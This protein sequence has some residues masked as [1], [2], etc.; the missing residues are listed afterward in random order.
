LKHLAFLMQFKY[1]LNIL[2]F[3]LLA[4]FALVSGDTEEENQ[5]VIK[6]EKAFLEKDF[7]KSTSL[8]SQLLSSYPKNTNYNYK[9]GASLLNTS[10][11]K[12]SAL[13]YL[14]YAVTNNERDSL[15]LFYLAKAYHINFYFDDAIDYYQKFNSKLPAKYRAE[16]ELNDL[17]TQCKFAKEIIEDI[18]LIKV[19]ERKTVK[20][21]DFFRTYR[22]GSLERKIIIVPDEFR[23]AKDKK[24]QHQS[25]IVH[26]PNNDEIYF[27]S[28]GKKGDKGKDIYKVTRYPN[29]NFSEPINLGMN[30]N[31]S[32]DEDYPYLH[33]TGKILYFASK[34]H[35]SIGGY[36]IFRSELNES[37]NTW[38]K[39]ENLGFTINSPDDDFLYISDRQEDIAYFSSTRNNKLGELTLFKILP[40]QGNNAVILVQGTVKTKNGII[41]S[42]PIII[43]NLQTGELIGEF[44]PNP[45]SGEFIAT[46]PHLTQYSL[47]INHIGETTRSELALPNANQNKM[48]AHD[49][50]IDDETGIIEISEN[51]ITK[52]KKEDVAIVYRRAARMDNLYGKDVEFDN[53]KA[54]AQ[55]REEVN[56]PPRDI[57]AGFKKDNSKF[58]K[59]EPKNNELNEIRKQQEQL[60]TQIKS[61]YA[62]ASAEQKKVESLQFHKTELEKKLASA[63]S[64]SEKEI[65]E[66]EIVSVQNK[67]SIANK[68]S[69]KAIKIAKQKEQLVEKSVQQEKITEKYLQAIENAEKSGNSNQAITELEKVM[70]DLDMAKAEFKTQEVEINKIFE[71]DLEQKRA[72]LLQQDFKVNKLEMQ[73][74]ELEEERISLEN[75]MIQTKNKA[76]LDELKL[77]Q[78]E[79]T[80]KINETN[81]ELKKMQ[82]IK[83]L[84]VSEVASL[85]SGELV[86]EEELIANL[87][88][89]NYTETEKKAFTQELNAV[90]ANKETA[91]FKEGKTEGITKA[92]NKNQEVDN[93]TSPSM[94]KTPDTSKQNKDDNIVVSPKVESYQRYADEAEKELARLQ[95]IQNQKTE[96]QNSINNRDVSSVEV[97][98]K[99]QALFEEEKQVNERLQKM[100]AA[101]IAPQN[102]T[103]D[104]QKT[105]LEIEE[106]QL[107]A[108]NNR[109]E[110]KL[111]IH[112]NFVENIEKK[113]LVNEELASG[114]GIFVHAEMNDKLKEIEK[115]KNQNQSSI[116]D[117]KAVNNRVLALQNELDVLQNE[118]MN[119]LVNHEKQLTK[120][121][122]VSSSSSNEKSLDNINALK[123]EDE[124]NPNKEDNL[125]ENTLKFNPNSPSTASLT[126]ANRS[127]GT[128]INLDFNYGIAPDVKRNLEEAENK[129]ILAAKKYYEADS[130]KNTLG[131]NSKKDKKTQKRIDKLLLDA[132]NEQLNI[133]ESYAKVNASEYANLVSQVQYSIDEGFV[134]NKNLDS[135]VNIQ[136]SAANLIAQAKEIR[137]KSS[138]SKK[139][140]DKQKLNNQAYQLEIQALSLQN[141]VVQ[142]ELDESKPKEE[143]IS[144]VVNTKS[145][146]SPLNSYNKKAAEF[147]AQAQKE[148]D[149]VERN[150]LMNLA[151]QYELAGDEQRT[152]RIIEENNILKNQFEV[153]KEFVE[154]A[155]QNSKQNTTANKA[156]ELEKESESIFAQ[157]NDLMKKSIEETDK[158]K[159][160][161]LINQATDLYTQSNN[162]QNEAIKTY[163][164]SANESEN[165]S[166]KLAFDKKPVKKS[167]LATEQV[168]TQNTPA[169][170]SNPAQKIDVLPMETMDEDPEEIMKAYTSVLEE[171]KKIEKNEANRID[172]IKRLLEEARRKNLQ[173]EKMLAE[174][175]NIKDDDVLDQKFAEANAIRE[176]AEKLELQ[177]K[178]EEEYLKN[179]MAE[180]QSK[181]MEASLIQQAMDEQTKMIAQQKDKES[182]SELDKINNFAEV[183]N[184]SALANNNVTK[185][186]EATPK[187]NSENSKLITSISNV[188]NN[189][190]NSTKLLDD[191]QRKI[192]EVST[193]EQKEVERLDKLMTLRNQSNK[194][195]QDYETLLQ[196]VDKMTDPLKIQEQITKADK[197]REEAEKLDVEIKNEEEIMRN[198]LAESK[199]KR[200]EAAF[201]LDVMDNETKSQA[202]AQDKKIL[203]N[204]EKLDN[205]MAKQTVV[206]AGNKNNTISNV[207]STNK[208]S[209]DPNIKKSFTDIKTKESQIVMEDKGILGGYSEDE[210]QITG[211]FTLNGPAT[212]EIL[213]DP[214]MPPGLFFKVQV[215]A[216]K[217]KIDPSVFQGI[218]PINGET[219]SFGVIRY[220]AGLFRGYKAANMAKGRI[221]NIGFRD[222]FVVAFYNGKRITLAEAQLLL[223]QANESEKLVYESV[224][225]E[226][227]D[228]LKALGIKES[229]ADAVTL[230]SQRES[231]AVRVPNSNDNRLV[232]STIGTS[233]GLGK[234]S[235]SSLS[236]NSNSQSSL[237]QTS[238][239]LNER[240]DLFYTVQIGAFGAPRTSQQLYNIDP[241]YSYVTERGLIKYSTGVYSNY[242]EANQR[243]K[244]VVSIGP[245]DAYVVAYQN[246]QT[247]AV[248]TVRPITDNNLNTNVTENSLNTSISNTTNSNVTNNNASLNEVVFRVQVG[249]Y[250]APINPKTTPFIKELESYGVQYTSTATGLLIYTIGNLKTKAEA[251]ELNVKVKEVGIKDA[252]VVAFKD[253]K[254]ISIQEALKLNK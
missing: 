117:K 87:M 17:I 174:M 77:Q 195:K 97:A 122:V 124:V 15:S 129:N 93:F 67:I 132:K 244:E 211:G 3:G 105:L 79:L 163:Q 91:A 102:L 189:S 36:D 101:F 165:S 218:T 160:I 21:D 172:E 134:A 73:L 151:R 228:K 40:Q 178:K 33:P 127:L 227:V 173:Y 58:E 153:R 193:I 89:N 37:T 188:E 214:P 42:N 66:D 194:K 147:R 141:I 50:L 249:A 179:N 84:F 239:S 229:E 205:Y 104:E 108:Q 156:F 14:Q 149:P 10:P 95:A 81:T 115:L 146:N 62:I 217:N 207:N 152:E 109:I 54:L 140:D 251:D 250:K 106:K 13:K 216:F 232:N 221:R 198:N 48:V 8:F 184:S 113:M 7:E 59:S 69:V 185:S 192:N 191:Y 181:R 94:A 126:K 223:D 243:K 119:I 213:V 112:K 118:M 121:A 254:R 60:N 224:I 196:Q 202:L 226:E 99:L 98:K 242:F 46:L 34:G 103:Q 175:Q 166:V 110:S 80:V 83:A 47:E 212:K 72:D 64:E 114:E 32:S 138:K 144:Y 203:D 38:G 167:T 51:R 90:K 234:N 182:Q 71:K 187:S 186:N 230:T 22:L 52:V 142:G 170:Q 24:L 148:D 253:G 88:E 116:E 96:L 238:I 128:E 12:A 85:E 30:I 111:D 180:A 161:E 5:L 100:Q 252:Y 23:S 206:L 235:T 11:D 157:A 176:E 136:K 29:G 43:K 45:K 41:P 201:L 135:A 197:L 168:I 49:I 150:R 107:Q 56:L 233:S 92:D 65:I 68:E 236:N 35:N 57:A 1:T 123:N 55:V 159:Q 16:F 143:N 25:L 130:L 74:E 177:A 39:A 183:N 204:K 86:A 240:N 26:N 2:L 82:L 237:A 139:N 154:T 220:T 171:A 158:L 155:Q 6:A 4:I 76:L 125:E 18:Q 53:P 120:N 131:T 209:D 248:Q 231:L 245:K 137:Q 70:K 199:S 78:K 219:T 27:S 210:L 222:A 75:Q 145:T 169:S 63:K 133:Q 215:G 247:V 44:L 31:T 162:K 200:Q 246:G 190:V 164:Q 241:L 20:A 208:K 9:Y 28:Y 225:S 61:A 19:L